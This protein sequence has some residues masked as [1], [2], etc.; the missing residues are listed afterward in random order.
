MQEQL[1]WSKERLRRTIDTATIGIFT[2]WLNGRFSDVNP[3]F[4]AMLGYSAEE[5]LEMTFQD[6]TH[7]DDLAIS[8][9]QDNK[10]SEWRNRTLYVAQA[11][12][13]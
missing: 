13:A 8:V 7:P 4:C 11:L 10:T 2:C 6:I 5:L 3:A 1:R 9:E 12:S